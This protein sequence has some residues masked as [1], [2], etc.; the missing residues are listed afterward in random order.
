MRRGLLPW[1]LIITVA[2][3][4]LSACSRQAE[5]VNVSAADAV[6]LLDAG[7]TVI[8]DVREPDEFA[9]GHIPGAVLIPLGSLEQLLSTLDSEQSYLLV[10]RSGN[11]SGQAAQIMVEDGFRQVKNLRGGMNAWSGAVER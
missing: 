11:R 1:L 7:E 4:S 6:Q 2:V 9:A 3:L 5:Y 8:I 10:C